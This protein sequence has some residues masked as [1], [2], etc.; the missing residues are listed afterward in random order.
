MIRASDEMRIAWL[1]RR[2]RSPPGQPLRHHVI[3][4]GPIVELFG[5]AGTRLALIRVG[6]TRFMRGLD[7]FALIAQLLAARAISAA[8]TPIADEIS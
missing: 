6:D 2:R 5:M 7:E 1:L 8:A 3:S 4:V